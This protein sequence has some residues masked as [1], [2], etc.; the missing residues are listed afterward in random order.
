MRFY[1]EDDHIQ[2]FIIISSSPQK[3]REA[4]LPPG[5]QYLRRCLISFHSLDLHQG[6]R[7]A[8]GHDGHACGV[9]WVLA[10]AGP[11]C[12]RHHALRA[13][14]RPEMRPVLA[15]EVDCCRASVRTVYLNLF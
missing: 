3:S 13:V 5:A 8:G 12:G 4:M 9:G 6:G 14:L 7:L 11:L 15:A 10:V 2:D 1:I